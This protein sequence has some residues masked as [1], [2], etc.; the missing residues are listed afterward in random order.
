MKTLSEQDAIHF[1]QLYLSVLDYVN[2]VKGDLQSINDILKH[3]R[4]PHEK[5]Q[6]IA[7]LLWADASLIDIYLIQAQQEISEEDRAI[8][9]HWKEMHITG[10]FILE[11]HLA[12]GS[13]LIREETNEVY[14]V[15]GLTQ[16]WQEMLPNL[17]PPISFDATL[18]PF[19]DVIVSDGLVKVSN[20]RYGNSY[21][22]AFKSIYL[23]AKQ[24]GSLRTF[25]R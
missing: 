5:L 18:L 3:D 4:K 11:R 1:M 19:N 14:L 21:K 8:L 7:E 25:L 6:A 12:N 22:D 16:S 24:N 17:K 10:S 15:K 2:F 23:A 20:I 13:V 9:L